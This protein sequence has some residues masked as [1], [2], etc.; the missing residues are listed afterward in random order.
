MSHSDRD[1]HW[2]AVYRE[3]SPDS[4]SW[5]QDTPVPTL[6]ALDQFGADKRSALIDIGGGA[7]AL[8]DSLFERG[9]RDLTVLDIAASALD[10]AKLRLGAL[11]DLVQWEVAD[12]T[13]WRPTR[14]FDVWHDRAVFHFLTETRQRQAYRRALLDG[15]A[16]HG[17]VIMAT[18][19][20]DGPEQCSGLPVQRYDT[21]T[22]AKE[23]GAELKP[24]ANWREQHVTPWGSNQAFNWCVF[25]KS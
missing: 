12:I 19:A 6:N 7:S 14:T 20:P 18:F 4:V 13:N 10:A 15:L 16:E 22:L 9:W 11:S 23:L 24:I 2:E 8:V 3:K 17:L 1:K 21:E 5:F 25:R